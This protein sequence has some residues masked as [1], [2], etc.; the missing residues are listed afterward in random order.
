ME[1]ETEAVRIFLET[2]D[3]LM[4]L[5]YTQQVLKLIGSPSETIILKP[6][7][8]IKEYYELYVKFSEGD[9]RK[10]LQAIFPQVWLEIEDGSMVLSKPPSGDLQFVKWISYDCFFEKNADKEASLQ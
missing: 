1:N 9:I 7:W 10:K 5:S 6:Y 2:Q 4:A 3:D 8:K